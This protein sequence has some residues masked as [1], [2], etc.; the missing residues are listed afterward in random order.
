MSDIRQFK[1][2][3]PD[4]TVDLVDQII[5]KLLFCEKMGS[6]Q[7]DAGS[8]TQLESQKTLP[9]ILRTLNYHHEFFGRYNDPYQ[10]DLV[11]HLDKPKPPI[12]VPSRADLKTNKSAE[13]LET[14]FVQ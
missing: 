7:C 5:A 6:K 4:S 2:N 3:C 14:L 13:Q 10:F 9:P 12:S 8:F 11:V 1:S